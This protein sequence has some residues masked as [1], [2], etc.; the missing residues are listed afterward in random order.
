VRV[1]RTGMLLSTSRPLLT[2][3]RGLRAVCAG[4]GTGGIAFCLTLADTA[5]AADAAGPGPAP[6]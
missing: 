1:A 6:K 3:A 2:L 5:G 4:T